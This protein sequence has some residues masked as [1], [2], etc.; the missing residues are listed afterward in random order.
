MAY[1]GTPDSSLTDRELAS[2]ERACRRDLQDVAA[3]RA[4]CASLRLVADHDE[5]EIRRV[6]ARIEQLRH[7]AAS[8]HDM[9]RRGEPAYA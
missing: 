4:S 2:L 9:E 8:R 1:R 3:A 6:L 5:Q 7:Q